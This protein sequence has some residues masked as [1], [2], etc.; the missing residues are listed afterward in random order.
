[1]TLD[2]A[3][4][5]A[6]L[7]VRLETR[8][9]GSLLHVRIFPDDIWADT[10]EPELTAPEL[11]D[12]NAYL[13]AKAAGLAA[14]QAAWGVLVSRWTA[15]RAAWIARAVA[16]GSPPTRAESWTRAA[17]ALLPAQWVVRAYQGPRVYTVTSSAVHTPLALTLSPASTPADQVLISDGLS[18]DA[19]LQ[20]TV[21][22][23]AAQSAGMAVTV[24]LTRP[25]RDV[26]GSAPV[27]GVDLLVVVG[28]SEAQAPADGAAQ[29]RALLDAQH[30]TR[31][32]SFLQ[33]GTPTNNTPAAPAAF[34]PPDPG[35]AASFTVE[36]E[37]PLASPASPPGAYG[38]AFARALGL[39]LAAGEQVAAVEH[40]AAAGT[41][42][43]TPA[44]AMNDALWPATLGYLMEQLMV[45]VFDTAT[46]T[47]ARQ[48]WVDRV[49]PAGP[50]PAFRVGRVPYGLLPAVSV[51]RLAADPRFTPVLRALRDQYFVP[52]A[53]SAP[54]ITPGSADPDGDLLKILALDASC[55]QLRTRVHLGLEFTTNA[56]GL[57]GPVAVREQEA[58][59]AARAAAAAA[60]LG[61]VALSGETRL[62]GLD[63]AAVY[64]LIGAPLV[65]ATP[66]SEQFGLEGADGTGLN[67]IR[68]L[69]D[70]ATTNRAAIRDDTLPGSARPLLY[71]LLRHALL[72]EMDRV[73]FTQ[74]LAANLV[75][76][77]DQ[78][79]REL[80][81]L[82]AAGAPLTAYERIER[83]AAQ[84]A[85][86]PALTS[87]LTRLA[88]LAGLPTAELD[89][90]FGEML[91][92]CSHR[93][94]AWITA[95]ATDRL[96]ALRAATPAGC[97][98]GGFGFAENIRPGGTAAPPGGYVHAPSAAQASAAAVLHNGFL[99]RGGAGSVYDTD[100]S[101]ARVRDAL[102][103]LDGTRQG[104]PLAALLGQRFERDLHDRGQGLE[105]LIAP[106]R[107]DF[108]LVAGKTSAGDGPTEQVAAG[109]V[110][111][112]L[113][114]RQA[115]NQPAPP[116][117]GSSSTVPALPP[118][119]TTQLVSFHAALNALN[120]AVDALADVLT[121]ESVF[122]AVRGNPPASAASLD[123][124]A[125]GVLPPAPE[126]TRSPLGGVSF[127]QRLAVAL[128]P[129]PPPADTWG[130][131]TPRAGAEPV[132]DHWV[133]TLLGSPAAIG[134]QVLFPDGSR[135]DVRLDALGLRPVDLVALA[136]TQPTG[137]GD[138]ELDR[139]VLAA[140]GAPPGA[141]VGYGTT[142]LAWSLADAVEL[143]R[144]I[145]G[146]LA[147]VRPLA[148]SDLVL[149]ADAGSAAIAPDA[150]AQATARAQAALSQL[151]SAAAALSQA[152]AAV[153]G[154]AGGAPTAGQLT[155]LRAAL[156][157]AAAFGVDGAYP[158][159]DADASALTTLATGIQ[160]ELAARQAAA[161]PAGQADPDPGALAAA[162][163]QTAQA[164]FGRDFLLLPRLAA[165]DLAAPL[166]A[167]PALVGDLN[168][169]RRALQQLARVRA[170]LARWRSLW[171]YGQAFGAPAPALEVAQLPPADVWAGRPGAD[172]ASGT[173]SLIVHRPDGAAAD[174]G[175]A[176]L[177]VDEWTETIPS[178]AADTA[179]SF[180]YESPVAEAPQAVLLAVPPSATAAWDTD[181]LLDTV[182]ETLTLAKIRAVDSSLLDG[183]RPFLPAIYLSS[184]TANDTVSTSFLG[185]IIAEPGL[186]TR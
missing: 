157:Q 133:G 143:A 74:L 111:D 131:L 141:Q 81:K 114:L 22:F 135:H 45:P 100:L 70:N 4:P 92:A 144:T 24:D 83:A 124:M 151:A 152:L 19:T 1:M 69:H 89:R 116:F 20:W 180:R 56:A 63:G 2:A 104:E 40:V 95:A 84:P 76:A 25:D 21:D 7:P 138:G 186:R 184:N 8:F 32:L 94:D 82:I 15:P 3:Y 18:I 174:G 172:V 160:Q 42:G 90:R 64:E 99:S 134:C 120:D 159:G 67:Y 49:R 126:V 16:A 28:V 181:T 31:G 14:E 136:R 171:L 182:R 173:L 165:G 162:A 117:S 140:A 11:A 130:P 122:Q 145:G 60:L 68:W 66:L 27:S 72:T 158:A 149:P 101:S 139:R 103:L 118:L 43:D 128:A 39:P 10:H 57:L 38:P 13:A 51:D 108:P 86:A 52:A 127:T 154:A 17:Q 153:T 148:P 119:T 150:A 115:W 77:Q 178:A 73:A 50:L 163:A 137:H 85:F 75:S 169:P 185:S 175:W 62:G 29:L 6:L 33:P 61:T 123:A 78:P 88:T 155:A 98:L 55:H 112:G 54:R 26:P 129:G 161:A 177:I 109:N 58:R 107:A 170:S 46:I 121:A 30:Y 5:I 59:R 125:A 106:L 91:D 36:R 80:V 48:F 41:D 96:W 168:A 12:G 23:A 65:T 110:V 44:A 176:G 147:V 146:L 35:G 102:T 87:Y 132:L 164:V 93:L 47:R 9:A 183:L 105:V 71:R 37:A 166:A 179:L 53:A 142:A 156:Q 79:E 34:P 113:A 97:H 167:S